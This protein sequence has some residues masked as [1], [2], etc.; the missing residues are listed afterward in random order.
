MRHGQ[1]ESNLR[2]VYAGWNE[3]G[4]TH[5]GIQQAAKA[6]RE[7]RGRGVTAI[8]S[9]PLK[10]AIQT[11]EIIGEA[12]EKKPVPDESFKELRLGPWEGMSEGD[13]SRGYSEEWKLWNTRPAEL[14]LGGR[15]TLDELLDRV[16]D[17]LARLWKRVGNTRIVVVTHVA[18][19]RVLVLKCEKKSLNLYKTINVPNGKV[20]EIHPEE[21]ID[22]KFGRSHG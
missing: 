17:G 7:L 21:L 14:V 19:V 15:E 6:G 22:G 18:I 8:F 2:E 11:A 20:F 1:I 12:L 3:E 16:L 10:R 5:D 4:L 9:S 13:I